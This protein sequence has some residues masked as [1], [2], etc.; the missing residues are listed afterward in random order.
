[1]AQVLDLSSTFVHLS[2]AGSGYC[3]SAIHLYHGSAIRA[4]ADG[5]PTACSVDLGCWLAAYSC[6]RIG[7]GPRCCWPLNAD[8]LGS[9][10]ELANLATNG[11]PTR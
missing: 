1:M 11:R 10:M 5:P 9:P 6:R 8:P 7:S 2:N 4:V 3:L